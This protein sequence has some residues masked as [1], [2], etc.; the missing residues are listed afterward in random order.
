MSKKPLPSTTCQICGRAIWANTGKIAHHGYQRPDHGWQTT[1]CMG[2]RY[3]P[4]EQSCDRI[5]EV[6]ANIEGYI[7]RTTSALELFVASPPNVLIYEKYQGM[8]KRPLS[9]EVARPIDFDPSKIAYRSFRP[10]SYD[11]LFFGRKDSFERDI[12]SA[13]NY[14]AYL[15]KRLTDWIAPIAITE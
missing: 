15:N 7:A 12:A 1:S 14:L 8:S 5:P 11:N 6:I 13:K 2:A 10:D 9:I 4:Y 3:L